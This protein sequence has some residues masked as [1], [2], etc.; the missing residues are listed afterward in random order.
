MATRKVVEH[1]AAFSR[2]SFQRRLVSVC[3]SFFTWFVAWLVVLTLNLNYAVPRLDSPVVD[4]GIFGLLWT[5]AITAPL[6]LAAGG[7][8]G[9]L[10]ASLEIVDPET[11]PPKPAGFVRRLVHVVLFVVLLPVTWIPVAA[12]RSRTVHEMIAGTAVLQRDT[13]RHPTLGYACLAAPFALILLALTG[14]LV[15]IRGFIALGVICGCIA[16]AVP[17]LLVYARGNQD[18]PDDVRRLD[19]SARLPILLHFDRDDVA[20]NSQGRMSTRQRVRLLTRALAWIPIAIGCIGGPVALTTIFESGSVDWNPG[21]ATQGKL[22]LMVLMVAI[23]GGWAAYRATVAFVDAMRG[24]VVYLHTSLKPHMDTGVT[25]AEVFRLTMSNRRDLRVWRP[26]YDAISTDKSYYVGYAPLSRQLLSVETASTPAPTPDLRA[27]D[28]RDLARRQGA[29]W[30]LL[31]GMI[32]TFD[33][34]IGFTIAGQFPSRAFLDVAAAV[35][36][37]APAI[38]WISLSDHLPGRRLQLWVAK[39]AALFL[40]LVIPWGIWI[41]MHGPPCPPNCASGT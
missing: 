30:G 22:N 6:S 21:L 25:R 5:L 29:G 10:V 40:T 2:P 27:V 35:L 17:G 36:G 39:G 41:A 37:Y 12:G 38:A 34:V 23:G 4:F 31:F 14:G 33:L 28:A 13:W 15:A 16:L 9:Q 19:P 3:F 1:G 20:L 24:C 18:P 32:A 11:S 26:V 7:S 8:P